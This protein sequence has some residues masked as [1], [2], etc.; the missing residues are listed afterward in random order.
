MYDDSDRR[1]WKI[2]AASL[3]SPRSEVAIGV[4]ND[5]AIV[6]IG[7]CTKGGKLARSYSSMRM[8]MGQAEIIKP[9]L[10]TF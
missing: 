7:G 10:I 8:E 1:W 9:T 5:N 4:V 3:S 6:V 2:A